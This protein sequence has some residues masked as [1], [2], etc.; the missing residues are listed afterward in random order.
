GFNTIELSRIGCTRESEAQRHGAYA[1]ETNRDDNGVEFKT[2]MEGR[3][4]RVGKVIG[5][6]N[7]PMA[8]RQNGGRVAAVSGKRITLDRA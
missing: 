5:I 2:G 7:A 8:G 4:P 6:N 1:I 3:I